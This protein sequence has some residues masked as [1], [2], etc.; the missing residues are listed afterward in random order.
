LNARLIEPLLE[1][2]DIY[3]TVLGGV[4]KYKAKHHRTVAGALKELDFEVTDVEQLRSNPAT[5]APLTSAFGKDKSSVREKLGEIL[6]T[7]KLEKLEHLKRDCRVGALLEL[8]KIWG[9]GPETA[10]RLYQA[11]YRSVDAVRAAVANEEAR[12][13]TDRDGRVL[14]HAQRVGLKHYGEFDLK[15]PRAEA[16]AIGAL[17]R[18][19]VDS[20]CGPGRCV[21]TL[22][23]S[24]RRGK[25]TCGDV[26]VLV[27]PS[28]AFAADASQFS[29][30]EKERG[31]FYAS[32]GRRR[33]RGAS[34]NENETENENENEG[35]E[36]GSPGFSGADP[37]DVHPA[38]SVVARCASRERQPSPSRRYVDRLDDV[39]PAALAL[40]RRRGLIT[41]DLNSGDR[42]SYMGVCK[43]PPDVPLPGEDGDKRN[44]VRVPARLDARP[45]AENA[46]TPTA[47]V[48]VESPATEKDEG[49]RNAPPQ[50]SAGDSGRDVS[51]APPP[52]RFRRVDI[53]VYS[54]EE[55]PFALLYFTGSGYFNRS[56]R[57]WADKKFHGLSLGD[58]G[59][60]LESGAKE[61]HFKHDPRFRGVTFATEKDVFDFLK[62]QYVEPED[63]CV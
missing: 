48:R 27:A 54:P 41:D 11:G 1:L 61:S 8:G 63:R 29:E 5:G 15:M 16:A 30:E 22:A 28:E 19:A 18:E 7:G 44:D 42:R 21:V 38:M 2:A 24:Y 14:T 12:G 59:F 20:V 55:Y 62:L 52:R 10:R 36:G 33:Q 4:D 6:A 32:G 26:D 23:G 57:W 51:V 58:K 34:A 39:L 46:K 40:L 9:V 49:E 45:D 37:G 60:R 53:K 35:S 56:M 50:K 3:E 31:L 47:E 43:L 13:L 25:E 17:V